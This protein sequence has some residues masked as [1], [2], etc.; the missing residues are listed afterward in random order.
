[1][2]HSIPIIRMLLLTLLLAS[3]HGV[4][5]P[6]E[7]I[8]L[9]LRW[10]HQFQ[11][12]GYYAAQAKGYYRD[13]GLDVEIRE[14]DMQRTVIGQ[15]VSGAAQY[16]VDDAGIVL[17]RLQGKPVVAL[18]AIFQHPPYVLLSKKSTGISSP[19]DL[20]GKR[21]MLTNVDWVSAQ[22][23]ALLLKHGINPQ[24]VT[25]LPRGKLEDLLED[26]VDAMSAYATVEPLR[27]MERGFEPAILAA[28]DFGVDFYGD[29]LFTSE[30]ELKG[31]PRRVEAFVRASLKGWKYAL[32]NPHEV[33]QIIQAMPSARKPV[34][35]I[36]ELMYEAKEMERFIQPSLVEL[37]HMSRVRWEFIAHTFAELG[38]VP[39]GYSLDGFLWREEVDHAALIKWFASGLVVIGL[40]ACLIVLWNLQIRRQVRVRTHALHTEIRQRQRVEQELK[41]SQEQVRLIFHTV[42]AG[43]AMTTIDGRFLLVN[44]A[45]CD[46]VGYS[47]QELE[48]LYCHDLGDAQDEQHS[49]QKL[50]NGEV[51]CSVTEGR[52]KTKSGS[53]V[54]VRVSSTLIQ[55]PDGTPSSLIKVVENIEQQKRQE[56]LQAQQQYLLERIAAGAELDDVLLATVELMEKQFPDIMCSIMLLDNSERFSKSIASRLPPAYL[57]KLKG[58][59]IGPAVGSCGTAAYERRTVVV[60]D[61]QR[62]ALWEN[63]RDVARQFGLG[64]CWSMPIFS[65]SQQLLGT[66]AVYR[67]APHVPG[68]YEMEMVSTCSHIVG[69]AIERHLAEEHLKLLETS[70]ARLNDIVLIVEVDPGGVKAPHI[71]FANKAFERLTGYAAEEVIGKDPAQLN[72]PVAQMDEM[73]RVQSVLLEGH[74]VRTE[75]THYTKNGETIWLEMDILPIANSAGE[76]MHWVSVGRDVTERK[77]AESRI[78]HL[79]FYDMLTNLPNRLLLLDRLDQALLNSIRLRRSGAL[80]FLDLDNFK[81]LN[82]THGHD[83]G[84]MLLEQVAQRLLDSVRITDTVARLGGD[85]FVV[86]VENLSEQHNEAAHE[87]TMIADKILFAL[88]QPFK[89]AEYEHYSSC[90]IGVALFSNTQQATVDELLKR[91]DLAMYQAKAAGRNTFRFFDPAMQA[92]ITKRAAMEEDLRQALRRDEM[93]LYYQPQVNSRGQW[94]G[95][96]ALLRWE[97]PQQGVLSPVAFIELAEETGLILPIGEW[98]L[99]TACKQLV[100]WSE[101]EETANLS[102]SVNISARQLH[103]HDFIDQVFSIL[104]QTGANAQYLKL[105]LT[106]SILVENVE[107][108]IVKMNTLKNMGVS[109]SMDDFGTGYSSLTYLKRL[110]LSQLK[111]DRSF[112][113]DVLDD[114]NDASIVQTIIALGQGLGLAVIAEG[115][116]NREQQL[117][118]EE[119]GCRAYQGYLFGKPQPVEQFE[120]EMKSRRI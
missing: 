63:Y 105:E 71:I 91:A 49:R 82:D 118:L 72:G 46:I 66:F 38:M 84:D 53:L 81:T 23:N 68:P 95:A 57:D 1:M 97:H 6:L 39:A 55:D 9:Q 24:D 32:D 54:W 93:R 29:T 112:V 31:H 60:T 47:E 86:V 41:S 103:Q 51:A 87:T 33:A 120:Q 11:F 58:L 7:K 101:R 12:A 92:L 77:A 5:E 21:V 106:E 44:P 100:A 96:E 35:T 111:I 36:R 78:Q 3:G 70:I 15:V 34:P 43:I 37:G 14:T 19:A 83:F 90:S 114:S 20:V 74:S 119:H 2:N 102:L 17:A 30:V 13:E 107:E 80:L 94:L 18:A 98:V 116:E 64:A 52:Y 113:R 109:F 16:G 28:M 76:F 25:V 8:S 22:H 56:G 59:Q 117:F 42:S 73:Q 115:V 99:Q 85:E 45:F 10:Y 79:A 88:S 26:K 61:I 27:M 50:L 4:A 110:P 69:I 75:L 40:V 65:G 104:K 62:D 67:A 48:H 108:T 89:L